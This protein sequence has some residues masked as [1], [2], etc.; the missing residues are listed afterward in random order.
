M[1]GWTIFGAWVA[2]GLTLAMYSF[3]YKDNPIFKLGEHIYVGVSVGYSLTRIIFE[4]IIKKWY[5]PLLEP[6]VNL[7]REGNWDRLGPTLGEMKW[8][9]L[10][11]TVLGFLLLTRPFKKISWL[12][13]IAFAFVVGTGAGLAIPKI[14]GTFFLPQLQDTV[15]PLVTS[16]EKVK[17]LEAAQG[18][19]IPHI[20]L[21]K[22]AVSMAEFNS[23]IILVGVICVLIYF[24]FSLEHKGIV[25]RAS[26]V[27]ITFLMI[28]FGAAFGF[29]TMGRI[30]LLIGRCDDLIA[31]SRP[32]Y[33]YATPLLLGLFV[34]VLVGVGILRREK[35][36]KT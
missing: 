26:R 19:V 2:V 20:A 1:D 3:L 12:S 7:I 28:S 8:A 6:L 15:R 17:A 36:V 10:I 25:H 13:R 5:S 30:S 22:Y 4:Y 9:L 21:G 23:L 29:T 14:I 35:K 34:L 16:L 24:F 33:Y 27:G 11:P 31:F 32:E 18:A